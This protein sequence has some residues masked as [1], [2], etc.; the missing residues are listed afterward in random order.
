LVLVSYGPEHN[1]HQDW[2]YNGADLGGAKVLWARSLG[3]AAD[4]P[5]EGYFAN[6]TIWR[7]NADQE[8]QQLELVS[9][10]RGTATQIDKRPA[11][12]DDPF[13]DDLP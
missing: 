5:L 6:R 11:A 7:L 12:G 2:I 10:P 3:P 9:R 8:P 4:K 1:V 13:A